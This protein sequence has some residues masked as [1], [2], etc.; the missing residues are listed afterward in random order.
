MSHVLCIYHACC[1]AV[2]VQTILEELSPNLR[3]ELILHHNSETIE[4]IP[5]FKHEEGTFVSAVLTELKPLFQMPDSVLYK[6]VCSRR[7]RR[8]NQ[9]QTSAAAV[10]AKQERKRSMDGNLQWD[11]VCA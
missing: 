2:A 3:L 9:G 7:A 1:G 4:R 10:F 11:G 6:Q 5:F 8:V